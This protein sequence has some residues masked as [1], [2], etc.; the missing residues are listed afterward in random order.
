MK[1]GPASA[2]TGVSQRMIRHYEKI[3]PVPNS[4]AARQRLP[5][6]FAP[7]PPPPAVHRTVAILA[8]YFLALADDQWMC[9]IRQD[10]RSRRKTMVSIDTLSTARCLKL[11]V[12]V[13]SVAIHAM[14]PAA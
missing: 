4:A 6:L 8:R 1:I 5:E 14:L 10:A 7:R 12:T 2:A 13:D 9:A 11:P 3:G